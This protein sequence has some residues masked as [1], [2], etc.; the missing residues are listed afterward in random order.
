MWTLRNLALCAFVILLAC[1]I[2]D[3]QPVSGGVENPIPTSNVRFIVSYDAVLDFR[4]ESQSQLGSS[5]FLY[6]S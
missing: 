4:I 5:D 1:L 3:L 6:S 2:A